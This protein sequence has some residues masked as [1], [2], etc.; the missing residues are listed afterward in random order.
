MIKAT[1]IKKDKIENYFLSFKPQAQRFYLEKKIKK[2]QLQKP[3]YDIFFNENQYLQHISELNLNGYTIIKNFFDKKIIKKISDRTDKFISNGNNLEGVRDNLK[4]LKENKNF[5]ERIWLDNNSIKKILKKKL[6]NTTN[7]IT[8]KDPLISC[9]DI[10][11][12]ISSEKFMKLL[13][14]FYECIPELTYIKIR[15]AFAN[16]LPANDTQFFHRD[17]GSFR[18]LKAVIYLNDVN[19]KTGPF[20]YVKGSNRK[21]DFP[22]HKLRFSDNEIVKH[23]GKS[24]I[25]HLTAK[26]GDLVLA[27]TTGFHKG[28][29][30]SEKDRNVCIANFCLH[31]EIGFSYNKIKIKKDKFKQFNKFQKYI[32]NNLIKV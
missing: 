8:I 4:E 30:P 7:G 26:R 32:F 23:Y 6:K 12:I 22:K 10:I 25:K 13:F 15:K 18:L 17:S 31:D 19:L 27:N 21:F 29:K 11:K 2:I 3:I 24:N 16:K 5:F 1:K 14:S 20:T 9:P 28:L